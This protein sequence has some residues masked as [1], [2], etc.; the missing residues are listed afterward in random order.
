MSNYTEQ[1]LFE[2]RFWL[3]ILQE[4]SLFIY[5]GLGPS[6]T[7]YISKVKQFVDKFQDLLTCAKASIGTSELLD[8]TNRAYRSAKRLRCFK[9]DLLR[10]HITGNL[11]LHL[12]PSFL[13]HMVNENEEYLRILQHLKKQEVPP[14]VHPL[15]HHLLW[16]FDAT[17]HAS[18]IPMYMDYTEKNILQT[19]QGYEEKFKNYYI[20]AVEFAGYI[21]TNIKQF[22]ALVRLNRQVDIEMRLFLKFLEELKELQL[23][24]ELLATFSNSLPDHLAREEHYY[25]LKLSECTD[26][27]GIDSAVPGTRREL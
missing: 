9:L 4:H 6:E 3:Q 1:C 16:L 7:T 10:E 25:L 20:K 15:H 13:N 22:P 24:D 21:R 27:P 2:H 17:F 26:M 12:T 11:V 5:N 8:L 18:A 23:G 19:S 14:K